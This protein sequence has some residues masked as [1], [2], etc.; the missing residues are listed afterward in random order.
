[1]PE[2]LVVVRAYSASPDQDLKRLEDT[3]HALL[4]TAGHANPRRP[5]LRRNEVGREWFMTNEAFLDT[6][7]SALGL[8][9]AYMGTSPF[10]E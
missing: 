9:T 2:P 4:R 1:M 5:E 7:A 8:R 6:I 3:F 10:V